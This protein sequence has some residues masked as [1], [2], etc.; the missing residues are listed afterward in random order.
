MEP[1]FSINDRV[2]LVND[3]LIYKIT[4][5]IEERYKFQYKISSEE[6]NKYRLIVDEIDLTPLI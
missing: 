2:K 3:D 1:K 6:D 4:E 5:V